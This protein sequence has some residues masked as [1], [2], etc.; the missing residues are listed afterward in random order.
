MELCM[1]IME[2]G[3]TKQVRYFNGNQRQITNTNN[4]IIIETVKDNKIF[5]NKIFSYQ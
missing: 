1:C 4:R 5:A 2:L 3:K